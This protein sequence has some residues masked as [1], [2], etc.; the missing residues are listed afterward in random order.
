M[1]FVPCLT[2]HIA[3]SSKDLVC[4]LLL[5]PCILGEKRVFCSEGRNEETDE[6]PLPKAVGR[7]RLGRTLT[8]SP[9]IS[10]PKGKVV[11]YHIASQLFSFGSSD[12][13]RLRLCPSSQQETK[14][15]QWK[16]QR[17]DVG[18]AHCKFQIFKR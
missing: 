18:I 13:D 14:S 4:S 6:L 15:E 8:S 2:L 3:F 12:R 17:G 11:R 16:D 5:T 7:F 10:N 1:T 9:G